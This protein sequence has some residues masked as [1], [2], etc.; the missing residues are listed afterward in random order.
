MSPKQHQV[1]NMKTLHK[2]IIAAAFF[3][4][5]VSATPTSVPRVTLSITNEI[6][7]ETGVATVPADGHFRHISELFG[8]TGLKQNGQ[9]LGTSAQLTH[10]LAGIRCLIRSDNGDLVLNSSVPLVDLDG[11]PNVAL[12]EPLAL[13]DFQVRCQQ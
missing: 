3:G 5:F 4:P 6:D 9:V 2:L 11:N 8:K 7:S 13:D 1:I 10:A 12:L